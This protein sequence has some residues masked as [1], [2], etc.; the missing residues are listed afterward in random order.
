MTPDQSGGEVSTVRDM[1]TEDLLGVVDRAIALANPE[2]TS[3]VVWQ[4]ALQCSKGGAALVPG[5]SGGGGGGGGGGGE[6]VQPFVLGER[7]IMGRLGLVLGDSRSSRLRKR[8]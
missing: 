6:R 2:G 7:A 8:A 4:K 5:S 3:K 1:S